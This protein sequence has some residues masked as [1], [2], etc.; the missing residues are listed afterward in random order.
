MKYLGASP[1]VSRGNIIECS[2]AEACHPPSLKLRRIRRIL[3]SRGKP[4]VLAEANKNSPEI[5]TLTRIIL[6]YTLIFVKFKPF[7]VI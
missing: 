4:R 3:F 5:F 7:F 1:E 2:F 6:T